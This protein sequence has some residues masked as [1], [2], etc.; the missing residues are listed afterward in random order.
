M[1]YFQ[2]LP[3]QWWQCQQDRM[4]PTAWRAPIGCMLATDK[5]LIPFTGADR[6]N[7]NFVISGKPKGGTYQFRL[8]CAIFLGS[9]RTRS[10][11]IDVCQSFDTSSLPAFLASAQNRQ[12]IQDLCKSCHPSGVWVRSR[13]F[14]DGSSYTFYLTSNVV[15]FKKMPNISMICMARGN[16]HS[17]CMQYSSYFWAG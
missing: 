1:R 10:L 17:A 16:L 15:D 4:A 9:T 13:W 5:H 8:D 6:Y 3:R 11:P 7:D 14:V 12:S 2:V